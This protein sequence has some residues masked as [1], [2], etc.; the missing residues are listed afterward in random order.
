MRNRIYRRGGLCNGYLIPLPMFNQLIRDIT[1]GLLQKLYHAL[2]K[3]WRVSLV[4]MT[5]DEDCKL[6]GSI[7][8]LVTRVK[9]QLG[10]GDFRF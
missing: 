1:S 3:D 7:R 8:G 2:F 9:G 10:R 5:T 6:T 4:G